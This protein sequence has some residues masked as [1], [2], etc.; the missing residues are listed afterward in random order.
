[1]ASLNVPQKK[2][3]TPRLV[4][5]T[6]DKSYVMPWSRVSACF[7]CQLAYTSGGVRARGSKKSSNHRNHRRLSQR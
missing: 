2:E 6:P 7:A 3:R 4:E 1:M 5:L